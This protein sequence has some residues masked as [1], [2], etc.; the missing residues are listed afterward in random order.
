M[1]A[2]IG[3]AVYPHPLQL[4]VTAMKTKTN[5]KKTKPLLSPAYKKKLLDALRTRHARFLKPGEEF[6]CQDGEIAHDAW[7]L[8]VLFQNRSR[9][10]Y[11]PID[12]AVV[13]ADNE[14]LNDEEARDVLV[15]FIDFFF[16]EYFRESRNV[17]LPIDWER[18][19][20]GEYTIRARGW[21]RNIALEEAAD[22]L[23]SGEPLD[24]PLPKR[25]K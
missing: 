9:T 3:T 15:D 21:E 4:D 11:L 14:K 23:L 22:K 19:T 24:A 20:F 10:L 12:M 5:T 6:S 8:S 25:L 17:T 13:A 2:R 7:T 1:L 18:L 16:D